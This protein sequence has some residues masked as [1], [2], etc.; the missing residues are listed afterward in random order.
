MYRSEAKLAAL[1]S[2][3]FSQNPAASSEGTTQSITTAA[4][5]TYVRGP[6]GEVLPEDPDEIPGT[7]EE[8]MERWKAEMT[9][10]FLRGEDD[11]FEYSKVDEDDEW[12]EVERREKEEEWF[13][14]EEPEWI[15]DGEE[16][17]ECRDKDGSRRQ[18]TPA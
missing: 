2:K 12:D 9:L 13:D 4:H 1:A 15:E 3:S 6:N 17:D 18:G 5:V 8:G 14:E 7:K 11:D 10:R 16:D